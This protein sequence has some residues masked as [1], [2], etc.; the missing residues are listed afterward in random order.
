MDPSLITLTGL[1]LMTHHTLISTATLAEHLHDPTW[2]IFDVRHDLMQAD[3]GTKQYAEGH[4]P[5]ACFVSIDIDLAGEKNGRNGR[6]PLPTPEAFAA[7]LSRLGVRHDQ[8]VVAYD[9]SGGMYAARLW[10]MLR[11][12]GHTRVAVLDGGI[13]QWIREQR[14]ITTDV[15]HVSPSQFHA[16]VH[17]SRVDANFLMAHLGKTEV[18]VI[19][20]RAAN[21]YAGQ[22]EVIDP[23]GG[24]IPGALNRPFQANLDTNGCF[25]PAATLA[26]EFAQLLGNRSPKQIVHSCGSGVSACHNL[27]AMEVAGLSGA[28]LYPGSWSEW[29]S[30]PARPVATGAQP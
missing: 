9:A 23:V 6:H 1:I 11:W 15:P 29:C 21:R 10:W 28:R 27:I 3:L 13:N 4:L 14:M 17:E 18:T 5:G 25:K 8:Q 19:D 30:D 24:H 2:R 7:T 12:V 20:A 16:Q 26:A 22:D